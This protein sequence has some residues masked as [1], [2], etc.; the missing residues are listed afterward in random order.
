[1]SKTINK[2][3]TVFQYKGGTAAI[4]SLPGYAEIDY[5]WRVDSAGEGFQPWQSNSLF[6]AFDTLTENEHYI[7]ASKSSSPNY[8]LYNEQYYCIT[9]KPS[10]ASILHT[11][12]EAPI[13]GGDSK[14]LLSSTIPSLASILH[15]ESGV[16][17]L[18]GDSKELLSSTIPCDIFCAEESQID[19]FA[20]HDVLSG[21]YANNSL[22]EQNC[23]CGSSSSSARLV[24]VAA[25]LRVFDC[26]EHYNINSLLL[27]GYTGYLQGRDQNS[28]TA[29]GVL[30]E[31]T[32]DGSLTPIGSI[33][34]GEYDWTLYVYSPS[35]G[36]LFQFNS[37]RV[38]VYGLTLELRF[39]GL[40]NPVCTPGSSSSASGS[41]SS[42]SASGSSSSSSASGSSSSSAGPLTFYYNG[43]VNSDWSTAGNWWTDPSFTTL[44]PR[45]PRAGDTTYVAADVW[46]NLGP[47]GIGCFV[48]DVRTESAGNRCCSVAIC[49]LHRTEPDLL[50]GIH[51]RQR[52]IYGAVLQLWNSHRPGNLLPDLATFRKR[53]WQ[54]DI[55]RRK[56]YHGRYFLGRQR[57]G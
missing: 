23:S 5:I 3:F 36:S 19:P 30:I 42:S 13:L 44:A 55:Q 34:E 8:V 17:I 47:P 35:G 6:N 15:T 29:L 53:L 37:T 24:N 25:R 43:A 22:C 39:Y 10:L 16:P 32:P 20:T 56:S 57:A 31:S 41:S 7:L 52:P 12:S 26:A 14:E 33:P 54:R 9:L 21:P 48:V 38:A 4:T 51:K 46:F 18:G 40:I 11:E 45:L 28:Q 1:M 49:L 50:F 27:T 2:K